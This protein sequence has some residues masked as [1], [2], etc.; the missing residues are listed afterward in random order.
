[1]NVVFTVQH[2]GHVHFFRHAIDELEAEGHE[3]HV[4]ARDEEITVELLEAFDIPHEVIGGDAG[5]LASLAAVQF[6]FEYRLLRRARRI[7]PDVMAAIGGVS[8]SHVASLVG[9]RSLAFTDTE[10]ASLVNALAHPFAD[11]IYTPNCFTDDV[12][13]KQVRY[14]GY[15]ELAYL[16]PDR[17]TPDPAVFEG[18]D[19]RPDDRFVVIRLNGWDASHDVGE[20]GLA[21]VHETVD[22]LEAAGARVLITSEVPLP[23]ELRR[24]RV[25]IDPRRIH[26][27]LAYADLFV[28]EGAT[29]AA[30]SAV[31]GTPAVYVN[32]LRMGYTDEI[33]EEYGLLYNFPGEDRHEAA[34][35]KAVEIL[36]AGDQDRWERRRRRLLADKT[37]TTDVVLAAIRQGGSTD[38]GTTAGERAKASSD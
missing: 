23:E 36:Q 20:S 13:P 21:D 15:H 4:F 10:H 24:C 19:A 31:L 38:A 11:A 16:H 6:G 18:L 25:D 3:T 17:F 14:P 1:M 33:D 27:L 37:D 29:M 7:D 12:G 8:V 35:D 32:S 26:D 5:S 2:P 30:E 28:G 9:A 34:L 22:R